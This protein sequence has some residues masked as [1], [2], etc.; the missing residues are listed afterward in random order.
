M[1]SFFFTCLKNNQIIKPLIIAFDY[2]HFCTLGVLFGQRVWYDCCKQQRRWEVWVVG[3]NEQ[4]LAAHDDSST[5][6]RFIWHLIKQHFCYPFFSQQRI[7]D[8]DIP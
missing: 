8:V 3:E 2:R 1:S 4:Q 7:D 6:S 5:P